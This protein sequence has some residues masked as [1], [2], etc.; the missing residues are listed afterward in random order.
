MKYNIQLCPANSVFLAILCKF[1]DVFRCE[2]DLLDIQMYCC[3]LT[4]PAAC[5]CNMEYKC[6]HLT[7]KQV[8]Y[9]NTAA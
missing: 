8:I 6:S 9:T 2:V 5:G 3:K 4:S 7:T 1:L